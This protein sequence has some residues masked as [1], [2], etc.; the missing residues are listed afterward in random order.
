MLRLR[1]LAHL[2]LGESSSGMLYLTGFAAYSLA[3]LCSGRKL[4]RVAVGWGQQP[5]VFVYPTWA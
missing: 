3:V 1:L 4:G 5:Y 2:F